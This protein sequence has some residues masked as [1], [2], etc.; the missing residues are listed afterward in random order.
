MKYFI[1]AGEASGDLHASNLMHELKSLDPQA[2]FLC[3][4]GDKMAA[5]GGRLIRHYR[6]MAFMGFISVIQ[7]WH[8]IADNFRHARQALLDYRPDVVILVDYPS[9]NLKMAK[10]VKKHLPETPVDYYISPK[11]WAWKTFRIKS[12]KKYIDHMYTIF[13]F[14]TEFYARFGYHVDYVGNPTQEVIAERPC[15][16]EEFTVFTQRNHLNER[17][18]IAL[19]AGS[20]MQEIDNCLPRMLQATASFPEYQPVIAGA[21]GIEP[22]HY[23]RLAGNIPVLFGQTYELLQQAR[24]AIVNSGTA[25]LE[26]ALIGTPQ[27]VVYHTAGGRFAMLLKKLFIKTKYISLVNII[28]GKDVVRELIAHLFTT[29][30]ITLELSRLLQDDTYRN[31]MQQAYQAIRDK[32]GKEKAA[33][34][35][36]CLIINR[37][38]NK[39]A[40]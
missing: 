8:K 7:N 27:V 4:G 17:P 28:A 2:D 18:I 26:T 36:A 16:G 25:T 20:R 33:R 30:N 24:A 5:Q 39:Y 13:P 40:T 10:F 31:S 35:A 9:F 37:Y 32:L 15:K 1:I 29:E 38:K 14:E 11:L 12:I 21:P 19:L 34:K 3:L 6:D 22:A 23:A